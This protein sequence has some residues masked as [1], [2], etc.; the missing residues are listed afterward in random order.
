MEGVLF[1]QLI[2]MP[3]SQDASDKCKEEQF[4]ALEDFLQTIILGLWQTFWQKSGPLPISVSCPSYPGSRL[5][6][7]RNAIANGRVGGLI[8]AALAAKSDSYLHVQ[9]DQ[10]LELALFKSDITR[11]TDAGFSTSTICEALFYGFHI[12]M[13]RTLSKYDADV[14]SSVYLLVL[15]S[16]FGGVIKLAGDISKLEINS[17]NPYECVVDWIKHHAE[18]S[19]SPID[20][21]WNKLGNV[22]WGDLGSLQILLATFYSILQWKGPPRKSIALL[23]ADH[24][25][26]M[27]KRLVVGTDHDRQQER[28]EIGCNND[29]SVQE[30]DMYLVL[31]PGEVI[32]LE[33]S[34]EPKGFQIKEIFCEESC[35]SYSVVSLDHSDR[36]LKM[37]VSV[38]PSCLEPSW[39]AMSLWYNVQRQTKVL[40]IMKLEGVSSKYLPEVIAS[41]RVSHPGNC[42]KP[43]A[44]G[45]CDHPRCGTQILVTSPVGK[46]I[47]SV[48]SQDGPLSTTEALRCCKDTLTAFKSAAMANIQHGEICPE[49][50][51]RV[52]SS[53]T[54]PF[55]VL[56]AWGRAVAEDTDTPSMHLNFSSI[57]ALQYRKLCP[58]SDAESL[59]YVLFRMRR[60]IS[61]VKFYRIGN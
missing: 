37:H 1:Q 33:D 14:T 20:Q 54:G 28:M 2:R 9:W 12:L 32:L 18:V 44:G 13:S 16:K 17:C 40:N 11:G 58:S 22:N 47:S 36:L 27:Q 35:L 57:H 55:Y 15:D 38:H 29:H 42:P 49:N 46:A 51:I 50:I 21:I 10:V 59:V 34:L 61:A 25:L 39:E 56:V 4:I 53:R 45:R 48:I 31:K 7:V 60:F 5:C 43:S 19:V 3:Y 23:A 26:R 6:T 41:G 8:G 52:D 24:S 30:Q